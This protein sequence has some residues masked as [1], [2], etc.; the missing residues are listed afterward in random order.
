MKELESFFGFRPLVK[1]SEEEARAAFSASVVSDAFHSAFVSGT[2]FASI[3]SDGFK[4]IPIKDV[5]TDKCI[6]FAEDNEPK[7]EYLGVAKLRVDYVLDIENKMNRDSVKIN[8]PLFNSKA[9]VMRARQ[10]GKTRMTRK[11]FENYLEERKVMLEAETKVCKFLN[12][13]M[14]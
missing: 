11:W 7:P 8:H 13:N 5:F 4:F 3:D 9:V 2:S 10:C 6:E 1:I 12:D 14:K